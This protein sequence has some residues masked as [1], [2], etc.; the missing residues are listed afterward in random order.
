MEEQELKVKSLAK[1]LRVLSCF[2]IEEPIWGVTELAEHMGVTKSNIHN[3]V[4]TFQAMGYLERHPDGR[5]GLGMKM[6]EYAYVINHN[7][8]YPNAVYDILMK[9]ARMVD[10][11]IYFGVP[12]GTKVLYLYVAHPVDK[13]AFLPYRDI[14]GETSP[15]YCTGIGKAILAHLP[16]EE[17]LSR[18]DEHRVQYQIN[19]ITEENAILDELRYTRQRGYAVDDLEH[20]R[21]VRCVGV[22]VYSASGK[23]VAGIS[24]SGSSTTMTDEKIMECVGVLQS[25]A[26]QMRERI[27][28]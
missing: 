10:E 6:L 27:Y 25:A 4:S 23:L 16:E 19:T 26:M 1:A 9:A 15:L 3:I 24:A 5:Y 14:L 18:L 22:P 12:Y 2:T 28:R 13:M 7:L 21:N 8:G 11:V 17:W 20:E